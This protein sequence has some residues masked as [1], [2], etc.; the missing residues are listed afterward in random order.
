MKL[1]V[2]GIFVKSIPVRV[3]K[4]A[5]SQPEKQAMKKRP[6]KPVKNIFK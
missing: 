3:K 6:I 5:L 4:T 1:L 2:F